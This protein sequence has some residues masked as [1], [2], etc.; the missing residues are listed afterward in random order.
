MS[1]TTIRIRDHSGVR[2]ITLARPERRNALDDRLVG[3]LT[4]ALRDADRDPSVRVIALDA[5]GPDFCA[6]AD[7]EQTRDLVAGADAVGNLA[8]ASRLGDLFVTMRRLG[9]VIVAALHGRALAGGAGLAT[10]CDI[11]V[12][13]D[14]A[15]LGYPEVQL[16]LVPAMVGALLRRATGEKPGF[17][18][19]ALGE[20]IDAAEAV[21]LGLV[22]RVVPAA[23]LRD[24]VGAMAASLASRSPAALT[25][26]KRLFYGQDGLSF[27]DAIGRGAEVNALARSTPD[28]RAGVERFL[29][30]R[31][32]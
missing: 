26:I 7:L 12:A 6:G 22:T 16:A 5:D 25:L 32:R 10:A 19:L 28:A 15:R 3:E 14:D 20:Q 24:E 31:R 29:E 21:R 8:D 30:R 18:L 4:A 23:R 27:E 1:Q 13:A 17:A 11:V 9:K 2:W